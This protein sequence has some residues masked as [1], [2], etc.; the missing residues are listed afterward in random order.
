M[1]GVLSV[2]GAAE[3][4]SVP[5]SAHPFSLFPIYSDAAP[6]RTNYVPSGYMGDSDLALSGGNVATPHGKRPCLRVNYKAS[7]PKGW[8]GVYWQKPANNWGD[9]SGRAGY[10]L[11]GATKLTFWA[12][13]EKGGERVHE[14]RMGGIVGLYPDSD[15]ANVT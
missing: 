1:I 5:A 4:P 3:L 6:H 7:G 14:F 13:G 9:K 15:V 11:R 12:R 2:G 8:A 10:D